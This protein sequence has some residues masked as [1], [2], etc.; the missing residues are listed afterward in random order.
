MK[1]IFRGREYQIDGE[2]KVKELIERFNLLP[3][4]VIV[5]RGEEILTEDEVINENDQV[6]IITAI[7]GG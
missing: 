7:S 1:V 3:E 6:V 5:V 2:L 4:Y